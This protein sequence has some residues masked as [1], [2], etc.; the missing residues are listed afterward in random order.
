MSV[1]AKNS[2][3][4]PVARDSEKSIKPISGVSPDLMEERTKADL[5]P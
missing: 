3:D 1:N 5:N 4:A 2:A